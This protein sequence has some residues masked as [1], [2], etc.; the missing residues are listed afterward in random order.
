MSPLAVDSQP[1]P[2]LGVQRGDIMRESPINPEVAAEEKAFV[3]FLAENFDPKQYLE[4]NP[5][6]AEAGLDPLAHFLDHGLREGRRVARHLDV[7]CG[8]R[9]EGRAGPNWT[10]YRWHNETVAVRLREALSTESGRR[11]ICQVLLDFEV[12]LEEQEFV[13]FVEQHFDPAKYLEINTDVAEAGLDPLQHWLN[14][15]L[16]ECRR[17]APNIEV[18]SGEYADSFYCRNWSHY[19]WRGQA[20]AVRTSKPVPAGIMAQILNQA[21]H[22]PAVLAPGLPTIANLRQF[23]GTDLQIRDGVDAQGLL[24]AIPQRPEA[25]IITSFIRLGAAEK[26]VASLIVALKSSGYRS[27]QVVVTD[28]ASSDNPDW[29]KFAILEPFQSASILYWRDVCLDPSHDLFSRGICRDP[30]R[31]AP[32]ALLVNGLRPPT[33]IVVN[34]RAGFDMVARFGRGLSQFSRLFCGYVGPADHDTGAT[35]GTRSP[36]G[37]LPFATAFTDDENLADALYDRYG[38][39]LGHEIAWIPPAVA[40]VDQITFDRRLLARRQRIA[41]GAHSSRWVWIGRVEPSEGIKILCQLARLRSSDSFDV[42]GPL[43]G[44]LDALGLVQPNIRHRGVLADVA[45]ADFSGYDGFLFTGGPNVVVEMSQHAVPLV[46]TRAEGILKTFDEQAVF[47]VDCGTESTTV[48]GF[49]LA[50]DQVK[51]LN[52]QRAETMAINARH[53]AQR[54]SPVVFAQTIRAIFG[55]RR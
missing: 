52:P 12:A 49:S 15:G 24:A 8:E 38:D 43:R 36:R 3:A 7:L 51:Q 33:T 34:S 17:I 37:T 25:L 1:K 40:T 47:L 14:H 54:H 45:E 41:S 53:Q 18:L 30:S 23:A 22:D 16:R 20:V 19:R 39:L 9:A 50:L 44:T 2:V 13:A 42:F 27:I 32:L 10:K 46:L 26:Y 21:R 31:E 35:Q 5:D 11:D 6:V 4:I 48:Q 55:Q 29:G 28:Q